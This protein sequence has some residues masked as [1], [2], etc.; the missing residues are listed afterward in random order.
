MIIGITVFCYRL[1]GR[2]EAALEAEQ[3]DRYRAFMRAV[4]RLWPS[5]PARIPVSG[6]L[7]IGS[8][9]CRRRHSSGPSHWD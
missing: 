7:P 9:A 4:P 2:E 6:G 3:G 1:I 5:L 8:M